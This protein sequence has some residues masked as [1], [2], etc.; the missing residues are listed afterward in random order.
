LTE[1]LVLPANHFDEGTVKS[2][3]RFHGAKFSFDELLDSNRGRSP[4]G[5]RRPG[6]EERLG[7]R[8]G[9]ALQRDAYRFGVREA[10]LR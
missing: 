2:R 3:C 8:V 4:L 6:K 7:N 5:F 9:G 10:I 1:D